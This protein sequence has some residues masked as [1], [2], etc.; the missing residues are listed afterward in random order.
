MKRK[1]FAELAGV[2]P[3]AITLAIKRG[4]LESQPDGSIDTEG[5]S[6]KKYLAEQKMKRSPAMNGGRPYQSVSRRAKKLDPID[7]EIPSIVDVS[8]TSLPNEDQIDFDRPEL[9]IQRFPGDPALQDK[10]AA[11]IK[12][13]VEIKRH[14]QMRAKAAGQLVERELVEKRFAS[15]GESL[16]TQILTVPRRV[17]AQVTARAKSGGEREVEKYLADE[18]GAGITRAL[19]DLGIE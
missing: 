3:G 17:A 13:I 6:A 12:K 15:F 1:E 8:D 18:I 9:Y 16:R 19:E 7:L 5:E 11:T 2:T 10:I 4:K 14:E